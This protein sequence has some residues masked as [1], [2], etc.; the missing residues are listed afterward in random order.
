MVVNIIRRLFAI[1]LFIILILI[2]GISFIV[3]GIPYWIFTGNDIEHS[4][5]PSVSKLINWYW[6]K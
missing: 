6:G 3:I 2:L 5:N 4:L 1:P